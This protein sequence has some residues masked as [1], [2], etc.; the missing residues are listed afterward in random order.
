MLAEQVQEWTEQWKQEGEAQFLHRLL[1][2]RFGALP[3]WVEQQLASATVAEL[4]AWGDRMLDADTLD[5]VFRT[6]P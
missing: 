4:E 5:G 1:V 2:R 6:D 3:D